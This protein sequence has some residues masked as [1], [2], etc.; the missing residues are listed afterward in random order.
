MTY[1]CAVNRNKID[2]SEIVFSF[3]S[4]SIFSLKMNVRCTH[5]MFKAELKLRSR[6]L[7]NSVIRF[8]VKKP[9]SH[10]RSHIYDWISMTLV[11]NVRCPPSPKLALITPRLSCSFIISSCLL[12]INV[13]CRIR[14]F[15]VT[16][17]AFLSLEIH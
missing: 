4:D 5:V 8:P 16:H 1:V 3:C 13:L 2:H 10:R 6:W 9:R 14:I 15:C 17:I 7:K 12:R 11:K